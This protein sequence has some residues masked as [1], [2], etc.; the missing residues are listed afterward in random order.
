MAKRMTREEMRNKLLQLKIGKL[1]RVG[2][3][4]Y[5]IVGMTQFADQPLC[6]T[7]LGLL[8]PGKPATYEVPGKFLAEGR[9]IE[10]SNIVLKTWLAQR[11]YMDFEFL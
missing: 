1:V 7:N 5:E 10:M 9:M 4:T 6:R 3:K 8:E 2:G 11:P